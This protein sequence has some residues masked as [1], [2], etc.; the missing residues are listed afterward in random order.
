MVSADQPGVSSERMVD[1]LRASAI[2]V[3]VL[4]GLLLIRVAIGRCRHGISAWVK[5]RCRSAGWHFE[6]ADMQVSLWPSRAPFSR[7]LRLVCVACSAQ[8][9]RGISE[10]KKH[11]TERALLHTLCNRLAGW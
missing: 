1:L 9:G 10:M 3:A 4:L 6:G 7:A 11:R 2:A 5:L 8:R